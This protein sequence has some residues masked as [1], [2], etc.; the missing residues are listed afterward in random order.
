MNTEAAD[1]AELLSRAREALETYLEVH[2]DDDGALTF[3]HNGVPCVIQST[4]LAEGLTVLSLTCVVG[5]DLP[6]DP[7]FAAKAA[8]RA[9][10]GLFGTLGVQHAERGLDLT[11]RYAF[12]AQG[13]EISALGTLLMLVVSTASQLRAELT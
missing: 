2:V 6:D 7:A 8:E 1:T 12:P 5:W 11:L 13:L 9:G 10:Q 4:Q 3:S